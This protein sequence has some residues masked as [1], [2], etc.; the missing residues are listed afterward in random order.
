M[1]DNG[2]KKVQSAIGIDSEFFHSAFAN[3]CTIKTKGAVGAVCL[4]LKLS[5]ETFLS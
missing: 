1:K 5:V 3:P 4:L 2:S